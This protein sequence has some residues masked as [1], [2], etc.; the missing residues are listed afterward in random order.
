MNDEP[1]TGK[2]TVFYSLKASQAVTLK[3][4]DKDG[5]P[6]PRRDRRGLDVWFGNEPAY[7]TRTIK[8]D[9]I[10]SSPSKGTLSIWETDNPSEIQYLNKLAADPV[11]DVITEAEYLK[12]KNREAFEANLEKENLK[13]VTQ[14]QAAQIVD[15]M[16]QLKLKEAKNSGTAHIK[17]K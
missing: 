3:V 13:Q 4:L 1:K 12:S 8:F 10:S 11:N 15:L 5:N 14:N 16:E 2:K 17:D 7:I 6:I 9:C